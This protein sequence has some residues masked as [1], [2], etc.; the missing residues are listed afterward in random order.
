MKV[1]GADVG[2]FL[3]PCYPYRGDDVV[4]L[5]IVERSQL[6][7]HLLEVDTYVRRRDIPDQLE[8]ASVGL[9]CVRCGL[10]LVLDA[11]P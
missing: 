5:S 3:S 2:E 9:R 1:H 11:D 4:P 8:L 10:A 6:V 7:R